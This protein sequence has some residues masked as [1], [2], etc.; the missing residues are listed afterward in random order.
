MKLNYKASNIAKAE[1]KS[2]KNF[3]DAFSGIMTVSGNPSISDLMFI[4]TAGGATKDDFDESFSKGIE[5]VLVEVMDG[6][7]E[8]GFLGEKID[9]TALKQGLAD[10]MKNAKQEVSQA[11][12]EA[13][14]A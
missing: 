13:N 4:Y 10:T 11:I 8:A 2:G 14:K 6:I 12:G 9:L 1:R 5:N 7:N 3:F